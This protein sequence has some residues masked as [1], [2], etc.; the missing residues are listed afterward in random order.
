LPSS[1]PLVHA[2][3]S[4]SASPTFPLQKPDASIRSHLLPESKVSAS[5]KARPRRHLTHV[6]LQ[7]THKSVGYLVA[8]PSWSVSSTRS[9]L[10]LQCTP[11]RSRRSTSRVRLLLFF[12][13][14]IAHLA[15]RRASHSRR[16]A[17][18]VASVRALCGVCPCRSLLQA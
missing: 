7:A 12:N 16:S 5:D 13:F 3:T 4:L 9:Y 8:R 10:E 11:D 1:P 15:L 14:G 18:S 2:G 6:A 17:P